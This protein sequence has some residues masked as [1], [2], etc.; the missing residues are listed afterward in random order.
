MRRWPYCEAE[1]PKP[2]PIPQAVHLVCDIDAIQPYGQRL[3]GALQVLGVFDPDI[4][5][6]IFWQFLSVGEALAKAITIENVG[7]EPRNVAPLIG[8]AS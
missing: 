3:Q 8:C 1:M 4:D 7:I 6:I 5:W 2:L